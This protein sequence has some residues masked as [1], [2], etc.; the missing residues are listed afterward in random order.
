VTSTTDAPSPYLTPGS[1]PAA[2]PSS[3]LIADH[4]NNRLLIVNPEGRITW[5]FP[6]L[7]P[8]SSPTPTTP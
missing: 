8:T 5:A 3:I 4:M 2:L 1:N 7:G 6:A